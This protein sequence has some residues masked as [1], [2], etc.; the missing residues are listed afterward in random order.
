[1]STFATIVCLASSVVGQAQAP[2]SNYEH[3]KGLEWGIGTW[4]AEVMPHLAECV[5]C[6]NLVSSL[7]ASPPLPLDVSPPAMPSTPKSSAGL[8]AVAGPFASAPWEPNAEAPAPAPP[9][10]EDPFAAMDE[11]VAAEEARDT[12]EFARS[13]AQRPGGLRLGS[14]WPQTSRS[15][16]ASEARHPLDRRPSPL[17]SRRLR[18][19]LPLAAASPATA[20]P[21]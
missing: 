3:L 12:D 19:L 20:V 15:E 4:V 6:A 17:S 13:S 8:E 9:R 11:A 7:R 1:M 16:P 14:H 21:W 18:P 5:D 2:P 10:A